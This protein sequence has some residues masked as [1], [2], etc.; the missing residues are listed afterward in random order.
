M[1]SGND[2]VRLVVDKTLPIPYRIKYLIKTKTIVF[3]GVKHEI[4][5]NL[6][7]IN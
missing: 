1:G 7:F 5:E 4:N 6:V 3:N 2:P